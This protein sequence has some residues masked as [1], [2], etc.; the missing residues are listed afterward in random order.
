MVVASGS[1]PVAEAAL[2][3]SASMQKYPRL[4]PISSTLL[5]SMPP[6]KIAVFR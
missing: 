2:R 6:A 1:I 4:Q 5:P 3:R